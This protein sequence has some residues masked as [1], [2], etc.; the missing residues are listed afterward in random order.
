MAQRCV[1][2]YLRENIVSMAAFAAFSRTPVKILQTSVDYF[3][4]VCNVNIAISDCVRFHLFK[5]E[6]SL[7]NN[8]AERLLQVL[9]FEV[10]TENG[11]SSHLC[12]SISPTVWV[13][14][15]N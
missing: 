14:Q 4:R 8:I 9:G 1:K 11:L 3:C 6:T 13:S 2:I 12:L 15:D 7:Q 10:M 5:G